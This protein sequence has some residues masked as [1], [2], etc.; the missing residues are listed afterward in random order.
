MGA[1]TYRHTGDFDMKLA[2]DSSAYETG[3]R[4]ALEK[5]EPQRISVGAPWLLMSGVGMLEKKACPDFW[6]HVWL[7]KFEVEGI[8]E[9]EG[10]T[11]EITITPVSREG[12]E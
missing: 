5:L 6:G 12:D 11:A 8:E 2:Y 9:S 10:P 1:K 3:L 4:M 7:D